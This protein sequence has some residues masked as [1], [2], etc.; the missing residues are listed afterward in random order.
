M[1]I[2]RMRGHYYRFYRIWM[3]IE[4]I[5]QISFRNIFDNLNEMVKFLGRQI[6]SLEEIRSLNSAI[7]IKESIY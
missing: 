1:L 2:S 3:H 6:M 4:N 5:L 7:F